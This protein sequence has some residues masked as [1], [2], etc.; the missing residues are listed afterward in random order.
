LKSAIITGAA[1]FL[2]SHLCE[3]LLREG[4]SVIG[5]DNLRTGLRSNV[6]VLKK[7]SRDQFTFIE[8]D[9]V[10][11]WN[12]TDKIP[13]GWLENLKYVFHFASPAS[14]PIYQSIP[15][16]TIWVNTIGLD[17]AIQFA[18][19]YRARV[20]FASTSEI[21]GD[22]E[23][24]PQKE[25]YWGNV[26]SFGPRS[27]YDEAKRLGETL[28]YTYNEKKPRH[29]LVRIFNTYGPRMNPSDGRVVI[30]FL[31]Q[32]MA[33]KNLTV[34]GDGKQTRS[35]CYVDDLINGIWAYA[36]RDLYE[37]VNIGSEF[38]FTVLELAEKVKGLFPEKNLNIEFVGRPKDDPQH[39][40]PDLTKA[41]SVLA[42][43]NS[44]TPLEVG[45]KHLLEW[46]K[47]EPLPNHK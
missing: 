31:V 28:L 15:L 23:F 25:T 18:D 8:A 43:W 30:N 47:T 12:W 3:K 10:K 34:H 13:K 4:F 22:P 26:N 29:G 5:V 38:Q 19:Q 9:V 36:Q 37:P 20:I 35:F 40:R 32:A 11:D 21:Y 17:K 27:C 24:S 44:S 33:G 42:P 46:L 14:P 7:V 41:R 45:L 16:E 1:G 39:R 6:E 2:G